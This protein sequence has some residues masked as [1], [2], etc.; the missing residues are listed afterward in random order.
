MFKNSFPEIEITIILEMSILDIPDI[1]YFSV[2][3]RVR[4]SRKNPK[5]VLKTGLKT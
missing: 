3:R 1:Y 2:F 5:T 4:Y